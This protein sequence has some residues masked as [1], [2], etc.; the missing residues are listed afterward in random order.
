MNLRQLEQRYGSSGAR[1]A[2]QQGTAITSSK[3]GRVK[4]LSSR[5]EARGDLESSCPLSPFP[6]PRR[7]IVTVNGG[8]ARNIALPSRNAMFVQLRR[9]YE[10]S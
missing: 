10:A 5:C 7:D 3:K 2:S 8:R 9:L 4:A 6:S 1:E